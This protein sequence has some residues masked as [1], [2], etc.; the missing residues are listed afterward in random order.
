MTNLE[1]SI[2]ASVRKR[3]AGIPAPYSRYPISI[4]ASV[5]KRQVS[6]RS[7]AS[8]TSI[9]IHASVRKRP[10]LNNGAIAWLDFNPRFRE[11]ATRVAVPRNGRNRH[12]NPRFREEATKVRT[13]IYIM[14]AFQSTLP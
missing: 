2:H 8:I 14:C 11:E 3:R 1:I 5:R 10:G 9:S 6:S 4:H 12:F 7:T 13:A